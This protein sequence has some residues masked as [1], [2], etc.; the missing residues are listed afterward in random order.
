MDGAAASAAAS[1]LVSM[2]AQ[3]RAHPAGSP[4]PQGCDMVSSFVLLVVLNMGEQGPVR[5]VHTV[6]AES[7]LLTY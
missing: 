4:V 5:A 7:L 3:R 6:G 2:D 1:A